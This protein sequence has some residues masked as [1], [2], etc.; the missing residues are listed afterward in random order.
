[1]HMLLFAVEVLGGKA[2]DIFLVNLLFTFVRLNDFV[3]PG[4]NLARR[5]LDPSAFTRADR[6]SASNLVVDLLSLA[7]LLMD[8]GF[9]SSGTLDP[10]MANNICHVQAMLRLVLEHAG[11][12]ILEFW[13]EV[14]SFATCGLL[15]EF[16]EHV[17][18]VI[19]DRPVKL[20]TWDG[21][22]EGWAAST[23]NEKDDSHGKEVDD[24]T[25]VRGLFVD[26]WRVVA[27]RAPVCGKVTVA[28]SA[29]EGYDEAKVDDLNVEVGVEHNVFGLQVTMGE[30]LRVQVVDSVHHLL[31]EVPALLLC[32]G[33][34]VGDVVE[35]LASWDDLFHDICHVL[36][37]PVGLH[38]HCTFLE[39]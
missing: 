28:F 10:W 5:A 26:L 22:L 7:E 29:L 17:L 25:A 18:L 32:E 4:V 34:T 3:E 33:P 39:V 20:I 6:C 1:M 36:L 37:S 31:E 24:R 30:S 13:R 11:E 21:V 23:H 35:E 38:N 27:E 14:I 8:F 15:V 9:R 2:H 12:Q 16:P 19:H